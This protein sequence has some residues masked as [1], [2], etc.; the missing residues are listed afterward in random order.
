MDIKELL[1]K[2]LIKEV[3]VSQPHYCNVTMHPNCSE[4][5]I[6]GFYQVEMKQI[7]LDKLIELLSK[8]VKVEDIVK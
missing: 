7:D 6:E 3:K 4:Y 5:K 1:E 2:Y 8:L